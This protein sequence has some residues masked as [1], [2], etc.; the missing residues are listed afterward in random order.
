MF[1]N[2]FAAELATRIGSSV[3][4]VTDNNMIEGIL[5]TVTTDLVLVIEVNSGYGDNLK[6]YVSMD[7]INYVR[8]LLTAA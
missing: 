5:S 2:T 8:F 1:A 6:Q 4:V 3:E 7:A